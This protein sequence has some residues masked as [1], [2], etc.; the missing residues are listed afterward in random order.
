MRTAV[1]RTIDAPVELVFRTVADIREFSKVQDAIVDV[2]FLT[3]ARYG[4]GTRFRE[5]RRMGGR[6]VATELEVTEL[7]ENER[8]RLV[9]DAGGTVWD[10]QFTVAGGP[11][12]TILS[13]VMD[14]R[15][16]G[17]LARLTTRLTRGMVRRALEKDMDAV[18][19]YCERAGGGSP[20]AEPGD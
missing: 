16:Y 14:A 2:A 3:D 1:T 15:P 20:G 7:V 18:K 10:S 12:G 4:V 19:A 9:S 5:T 11:G 13:L 17:L 8:I 6:E